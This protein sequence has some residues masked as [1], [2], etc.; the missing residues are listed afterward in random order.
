MITVVRAGLQTTIQDAGRAGLQ[1]LGVPP[2]GPMDPWSF[3]LANV[4][5]GNAPGDAALEVTLAGP[6]LR[7]DAGMLIAVCGADLEASVG[8]SAVPLNEPFAVEPGSA[9]AF[10]ERRHGARAYVAVRGGIDVPA[11]LGSRATSLQARL[12]GLAGRAL[13]AGDRLPVGDRARRGVETDVM[14]ELGRDVT[15]PALLRILPGPDLDRLGPDALD[16]LTQATYRIAPQSNRMGYRLD[17]PAILPRAGGRLLSEASPLGSIQVPP[18][19]R[20]ILLMADRQTTG[21]YP[22]IGTVITAD[23]PVAGQLAPGDLLRFETTDRATAVA[24]LRAQA[25]F[26]RL[27]GGEA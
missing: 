14:I 3:R 20:P 17:G 4:L 10:G 9:L 19:G 22:R 15:R 12:P 11:V 21:G 24:Q 18:G 13:R 16:R 1:H 6:E 7:F 8:R 27:V 26:L 23:I 25:A 2:A 5:V